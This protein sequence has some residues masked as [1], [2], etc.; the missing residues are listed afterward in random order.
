MDYEKAYSR[1]QAG[2]IVLESLEGR[3]NLYCA[4][5]YLEMAKLKKILKDIS[6]AI[7]D[8]EKALDAYTRIF[9]ITNT[10]CLTIFLSLIELAFVTHNMTKLADYTD[11]FTKALDNNCT[12]EAFLLYN[13]LGNLYRNNG[14]AEDSII[15]YQKAM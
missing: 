7:S 10:Q 5:A 6:T 9:G 12:V 14:C 1:F 4:N 8:Y 11:R 13:E 3:A 2:T 15:F